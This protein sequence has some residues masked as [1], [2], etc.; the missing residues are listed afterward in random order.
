MDQ[1][2]TALGDYKSSYRHLAWSFRNSRDRWKAKHQQLK[3]DHKL[4]QNQ[5][6][7]VTA[8]REQHKQKAVAA[9][10]DAQQSQE[11][12]AA[13]Q[14]Q[15]DSLQQQLQQLQQH[16]ASGEKGGLIALFLSPG[17]SGYRL[18]V[19]ASG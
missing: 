7:A 3:H 11:H 12:A 14:R 15:L 5:L 4:L 16:A 13:L 17:N 9:C 8:S 18:R 2:T 6:R 10:H 1:A 19:P